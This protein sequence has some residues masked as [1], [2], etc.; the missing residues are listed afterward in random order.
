MD[1]KRCSHTK[2][3]HQYIDVTYDKWGEEIPAHWDYSGVVDTLVNHDK[4]N[5]KCTICG[6]LVRKDR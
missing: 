6:S 1:P 3:N 5:Y 2:A 4:N